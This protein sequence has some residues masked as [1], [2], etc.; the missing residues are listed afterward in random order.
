MLGAS[1]M[2]GHALNE[3]RNHYEATLRPARR[4]NKQPLSAALLSLAQLGC[5]SSQL[6]QR[7]VE[8][9]LDADA[10]LHL[11]PVRDWQLALVQVL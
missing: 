10:R 4:P 5:L 8:G 6:W 3:D 2:F 9:A 7:A 11:C 1:V